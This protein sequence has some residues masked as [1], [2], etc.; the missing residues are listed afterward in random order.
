MEV[1]PKGTKVRQIV[2]AIEG[3]VESTRFNES[4]QSLEYHVVFKTEDGPHGIWFT[5]AQIEVAPDSAKPAADSAKPVAEAA[6]K[7]TTSKGV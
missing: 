2:K 6:P 1:I 7:L 4:A 3:V 5:S